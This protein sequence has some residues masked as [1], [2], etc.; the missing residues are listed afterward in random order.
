MYIKLNSYYYS[1]VYISYC[2]CVLFI[3]IFREQ[4]DESVLELLN[5]TG[6]EQCRVPDVCKTR[7]VSLP[8]WVRGPAQRPPQRITSGA[9]SKPHWLGAVLGARCL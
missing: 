1:C 3:F 9:H 5:S 7:G 8:A 4:S 6:S 2:F